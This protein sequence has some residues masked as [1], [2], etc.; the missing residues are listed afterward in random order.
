MNRSEIIKL[1]GNLGIDIRH[2]GEDFV[3]VNGINGHISSIRNYEDIRSHLLQ[4]GRDSLKRD[5]EQL[6]NITKHI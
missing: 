5:L 6:L 4:M 2:V 1:L 3:S